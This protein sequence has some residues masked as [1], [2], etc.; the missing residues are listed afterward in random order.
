MP[1]KKMYD[2][3][4]FHLTMRLQSRYNDDN[5][6]MAIRCGRWK[7]TKWLSEREVNTKK[8][9]KQGDC[10]VWPPRLGNKWQSQAAPRVLLLKDLGPSSHPVRPAWQRPFCPFSYNDN[11]LLPGT[12]RPRA[13]FGSDL[14]YKRSL[15]Q[16]VRIGQAGLI[17]AR[18]V[19]WFLR[20]LMCVDR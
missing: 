1:V 11:T 9:R 8:A 5:L 12:M 2:S 18:V 20:C 4:P 7:W 10:F 15:M 3:Q 13:A 6:K 17:A 16:Q 19:A 14:H